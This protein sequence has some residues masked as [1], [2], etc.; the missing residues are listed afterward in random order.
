MTFNIAHRG[1]AA[2]F[3]E[4]ILAAF[5]N[6]VALGCDGA[7]LDVQLSRDAEVV[8]FHDYC[9]KAEICRAS[10]AWLKPPT[11]RIKDLPLAE[12]RAFDI[13]RAD[14]ASEYA[15]THSFV[16]PID[17]ARIPILTEVIEVAKT[18]GKPF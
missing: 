16:R 8:V 3:P 14:P 15:R 7:E 11:P 17:G 4:N 6:A 13:G 9:L 5:R 10:G 12:V 2:L 1:G 18:A